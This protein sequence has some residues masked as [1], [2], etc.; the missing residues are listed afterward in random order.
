MNWVSNNIILVAIIVV[1]VFFIIKYLQS[2][3]YFKKI[4]LDF[5]TQEFK[6]T[7]QNMRGD[8]DFFAPAPEEKIGD[9]I[10]DKDNNKSIPIKKQDDFFDTNLNIN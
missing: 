1:I 2:S 9:K 5:N 8:E 7:I 3:G 6:K 10:V 4:G